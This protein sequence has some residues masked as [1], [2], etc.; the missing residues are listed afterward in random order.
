[1]VLKSG[2]NTPHGSTRIYFENEDLQSNNMPDGSGGHDRRH[3]RQGQPHAPVQRLRL[4]ARRPDPQGPAVGLG[5]DRQD[6]RGPDHARP[7]RTIAPSCRTRRSR[8]PARSPTAS[9]RTS[10]SSAA[11]RRSSAAAPAPTRRRRDHLQPD[12]AR[13]RCTRAKSTSSSATTCSSSAQGRARRRRLLARGRA[14]APTTQT[15]HRTTAA[16]GAD[17]P[18]PT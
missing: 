13:P 2:T 10:P 8:P 3:D 12:A 14:A 7:A 6:P 15:V 1:M 11:T 9:A 4:R 18:T 5:R 16:C 17:R